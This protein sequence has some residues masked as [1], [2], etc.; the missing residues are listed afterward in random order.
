MRLRLEGWERSKEVSKAA[1]ASG[2]LSPRFIQ[3]T[4][5]LIQGLPPY[6]PKLQT[7]GMFFPI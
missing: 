5:F 1:L 4:Q 2:L 3:S 7:N 6:H